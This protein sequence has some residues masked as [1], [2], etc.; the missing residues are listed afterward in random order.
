MA[1]VDWAKLG[2]AMSFYEGR[3]Y[4]PIEV[5]WVVDPATIRMT[6]SEPYWPTQGGALVA[7]AEQSFLQLCNDGKLTPGQYVA[8]SPCFRNDE[9]DDLH[10]PYFMKVELFV[11]YNDNNVSQTNAA[12]IGMDAQKFFSKYTDFENLPFE[13]T[14][15]GLDITLGGIEIG[16]YGV[17]TVNGLTWTYG[18]GIAEPRFSEALSR[19]KRPV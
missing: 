13:R 3:G 17:R 8:C 6:S 15:Q 16:S 11:L 9:P 18:T 14:D 7:S 10:L 1:A 4:T 5:P 12:I 19:L 2:A